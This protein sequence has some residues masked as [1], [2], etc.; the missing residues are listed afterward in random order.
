MALPPDGVAVLNAD[1]EYVLRMREISRAKVVTFAQDAPADVTATHIVVRGCEGTEFRL[2][3]REGTCPIWLPAPGRHNVRNALAAAGAALAAGAG[4]DDIQAA[5][6]EFAAPPGRATV[7]HAAAGYTII[8]DT[9]NASPVSVVAA[10]ELMAQC[11]APGRRVVVLGDMLELGE[12]SNRAHR[13]LAKEMARTGVA[14]LVT[15]GARARL[16]ADAGAELDNLQAHPF[17]GRAE[18]LAFLAG[19]LRPGDI[20]LVKGS[21]AMAMEEV[22]RRLVG[23]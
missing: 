13:Q 4:T 15:V 7:I 6:A 8:D 2:R 9:Y 10:L 21:R 11:P 12:H 23:D 19:E 18:A 17:D 20:V 5:L 22:V 1:D 16:T 14:I 3:T